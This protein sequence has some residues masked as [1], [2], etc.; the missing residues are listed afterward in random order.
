M[1][2]WPLDRISFEH[3]HVGSAMTSVSSKLAAAS[4]LGDSKEGYLFNLT[5]KQ[6]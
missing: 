6:F 2:N 3:F 4:T 1:P 5:C